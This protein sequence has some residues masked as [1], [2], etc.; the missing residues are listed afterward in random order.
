[1]HN[2]ARFHLAAILTAAL[3]TGATYS[4]SSTAAQITTPIAGGYCI[5][6]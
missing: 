1:M 5:E 2:Q 4:L 3:F 6:P